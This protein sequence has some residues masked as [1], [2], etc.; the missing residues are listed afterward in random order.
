MPLIKC[1][2]CQQPLEFLE[3]ATDRSVRWSICDAC[4]ANLAAELKELA[5]TDARSLASAL[6][7][8]HP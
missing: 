4:C 5:M 2:R 1:H 6:L 8:G 7:S 3:P